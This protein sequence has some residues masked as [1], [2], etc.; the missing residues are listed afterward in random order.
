MMANMT[1]TT[2]QAAGAKPSKWG[3][4]DLLVVMTSE[5]QTTPVI[6]TG[7]LA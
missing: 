3:P 1:D 6:N 5:Q 7:S 2:L 4:C